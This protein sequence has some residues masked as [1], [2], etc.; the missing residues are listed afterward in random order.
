[1]P[2]VTV[3][4]TQKQYEEFKKQAGDI[5][6]SRWLRTLG[7]NETFWN[8]PPTAEEQKRIDEFNARRP[9]IGDTIAIKKPAPFMPVN[10][11]VTVEV[12]PTPKATRAQYEKA[13]KK[14]GNVL[15]TSLCQHNMFKAACPRCK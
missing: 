12:G 1:M 2:R 5:P 11:D 14:L 4:L 10:Y 8:P 6:L 15:D 9:K 3:I 13:A 7:S